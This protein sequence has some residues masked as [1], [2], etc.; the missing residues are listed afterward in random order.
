M[1]SP[2]SPLLFL[3]WAV[4]ALS[5]PCG[6]ISSNPRHV[7]TVLIVFGALCRLGSPRSAFAQVTEDFTARSPAARSHSL[8]PSFSKEMAHAARQP[9]ESPSLHAPVRHLAC[10]SQSTCSAPLIDFVGMCA[11]IRTSAGHDE[12]RRMIRSYLSAVLRLYS[13][14]AYL[15][16]RC[17]EQDLRPNISMEPGA[18]RPEPRQAHCRLSSIK[19]VSGLK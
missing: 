5:S 6:C 13:T 18:G 9:G 17:S 4:G 15:K 7:S 11:S 12:C 2:V 19:A 14:S 3:I 10:T 8:D 1:E 16:D